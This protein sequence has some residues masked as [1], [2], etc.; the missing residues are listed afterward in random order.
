MYCDEEAV[1]AIVKS[2]AIQ[3]HHRISRCEEEVT[4]LNSEMVNCVDHYLNVYDCLLKCGEKFRNPDDEFSLGRGCL[5]EMAK[6]K[7][8]RQ[9]KSFIYIYFIENVGIGTSEIDVIEDYGQVSTISNQ[10]MLNV[11]NLI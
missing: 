10:G 3:L 5:L 8:I 9:L 6:A 1:P 11:F 2:Q 4:Q 7:C